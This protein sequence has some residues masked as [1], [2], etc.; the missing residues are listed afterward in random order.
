MP[1][2]DQQLDTTKSLLYA[3]NTMLQAIGSR[4]I[5]TD[6]DILNLEEAKIAYSILIDT[7]KEILSEGWDFNTDKNYTFVQ[8]ADGFITIPYNVLDV[9]DSTGDLISRDWRLYS[10][11]NQSGKFTEPQSIDVKWDLD[12]NSLTHPVRNLITIRASSKFV[13][14]TTGDEEVYK[15]LRYE[16]EEARGTAR[17]SEGFTGR[18]NMFTS[19]YGSEN[20]IG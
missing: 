1:A 18:Y 14:R 3:I 15:M 19:A 6:E 9:S 2:L 12:F 5:E 7:K 4:P 17:R 8:D 10:K 11:S 13:K 16:E 20:I